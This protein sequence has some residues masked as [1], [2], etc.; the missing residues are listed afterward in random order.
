MHHTP[1][2]HPDKRLLRKRF[3]LWEATLLL[4]NR[5]GEL[6]MLMRLAESLGEALEPGSRSRS[7]SA[8]SACVMTSS[9]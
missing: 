8:S 7:S 9:R 3:T 1:S 2:E 5:A 4:Q 6:E